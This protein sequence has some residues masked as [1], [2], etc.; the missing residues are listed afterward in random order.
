M[1]PTANICRAERIF[2]QEIN[3]EDE[4]VQQEIQSLINKELKT[5]LNSL[6]NDCKTNNVDILGIERLI[7]K[8][9]Y[10]EYEKFKDLNYCEV[11]KFNL[12]V[13]AKLFRYGNT[14]RSTKG[15]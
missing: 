15:E 5:Y 12:N 6:I 3:L 14:Y 13:S 1:Q 8:N 11:A 2:R 7:Y 4:K 9:H 10:K